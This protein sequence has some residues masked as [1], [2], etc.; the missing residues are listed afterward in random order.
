M[1]VQSVFPISTIDYISGHVR[2]ALLLFCYFSQVDLSLEKISLTGWF[3]RV[4]L[5]DGWW[6]EPVYNC[7]QK[8]S[9]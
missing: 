6:I 1:S 7:F 5:C 2:I 9:A 4:A 3:L 8:H